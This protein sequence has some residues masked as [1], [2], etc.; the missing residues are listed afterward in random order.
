MIDALPDLERDL[1]GWVNQADTHLAL[2]DGDEL[3]GFGARTK[4]T[5]HPQRDLVA[6]FAN[7]KADLEGIY[8]ALPLKKPVKARVAAHD[9]EHLATVRALGFSERIRSA[10]YRVGANAFAGTPE[11]PVIAM[12]DATREL[13]DAF[14]LL[15]ADTHQWDPPA[16]YTRRYVRQSMMNGAQQMAVIRDDDGQIVG[17]GAAHRSDD[18]T[19][20]ADIA[21]VG[22]L[23]QAVADAAAITRS[24]L[25]HLAT[26][27]EDAR[28]PLWFEVD[29]GEGTNVAL[30]NLVTPLAPAGDEVVILTSD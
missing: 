22:P 15:Y 9:A 21:L 5:A 2:V 13:T 17:V 11:L 4:H 29:T 25:A 20:A 26:F 24:L 7:D 6:A 27:Y 16:I 19:V 18:P 30:A 28:A 1:F 23:E 10:T 3:T 8:R 12:P 14:T